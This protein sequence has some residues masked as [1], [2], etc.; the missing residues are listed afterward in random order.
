MRTPLPISVYMLSFGIFIMI[1]CELQVLGMMEQIS[2]ALAISIAQTGHLVSIFAASM[3]IGGPIL[4]ILVSRLA[5]KK[6]LMMLYII[7]ILGE[8]LGGFSNTL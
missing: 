3:A 2:A 6:T 7:F 5:V 4:A 1:S 8:L